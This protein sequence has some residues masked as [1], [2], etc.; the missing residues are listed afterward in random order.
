M[1]TF[2]RGPY[3]SVRPERFRIVRSGVVGA[4]L[5]ALIAAACGGVSLDPVASA[6]DRTLD[7]QTGSFEMAVKV[8]IP[9]LGRTT[10]RG[11]GTFDVAEHA[12]AATIDVPGVGTPKS[13][14]ETRMLYPVTYIRFAALPLPSGKSWLKVDLRKAAAKRGMALPEFRMGTNPSPM[15][16]LAKLRGSKDAK[17]VGADTIDGV[18][19]THYRVKID[20][21]KALARATPRQ[22]KALA[23]LIRISRRNGVDIVPTDADVW[24]G[25]DGLVRRFDE[26]FG[27]VGA[28]TITFSDYGEPVHVEA[29]PPDQTV[30]LSQ[31]G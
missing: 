4:L 17:K 10:I 23:Q 13:S 2:T 30:D 1:P 20:V 14:M 25:E 16:A 6:A 8:S 27:R 29:P 7:R 19:A 12:F 26:T 22:R 15:D 31:L 21:D 9:Q 18:I 3:P 11:R 28:I 5:I 24:V